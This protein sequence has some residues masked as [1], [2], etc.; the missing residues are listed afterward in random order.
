MSD[1]VKMTCPNCSG[2]LQI[3]ANIQQFACSFCGQEYTVNRGGGIVS[4]EPIVEGLNRIHR[5]VDQTAS[6]LAIQRLEREIGVLEDE[7]KDIKTQL[8]NWATLQRKF[9]KLNSARLRHKQ[10]VRFVGTATVATLVIGGLIIVIALLVAN[11]GGLFRMALIA[12]IVIPVVL[13]I[14][15]GIEG[16]RL[17]KIDDQPPNA[18]LG[19]KARELAQKIQ[20]AQAA[21]DEKSKQI[22][23][24]RQH[25]QRHQQIVSR[26][27]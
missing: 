19:R 23:A 5:G 24:K 12:T 11:D 20:S 25:L 3:G 6:E 14:V 21:L 27:P 13:L 9:Q 7:V 18:N 26:L 1:F 10:Y 22:D 4:V 16:D 8:P 17:D 15:L 2:K